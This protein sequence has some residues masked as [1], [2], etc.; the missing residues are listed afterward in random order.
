MVLCLEI[1]FDVRPSGEGIDHRVKGTLFVKAVF[2]S[3]T[4]EIT[5]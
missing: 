5:E 3:C 1:G 2:G 4:Y